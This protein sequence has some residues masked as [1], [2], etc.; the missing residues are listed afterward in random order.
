[1][2]ENS[3]AEAPS[4][5]KSQS[6]RAA[7]T[8]QAEPPTLLP[9]P[10]TQLLSP[11]HTGKDKSEPCMHSGTVGCLGDWECKIRVEILLCPWHQ[12]TGTQR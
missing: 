3:P 8:A 1:M 12:G 5:E 10:V 6:K 11:M 4:C 9:C 2:P 7:I